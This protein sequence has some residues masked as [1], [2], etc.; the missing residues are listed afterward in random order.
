MTTTSDTY[1]FTVPM[2]PDLYE[3]LKAHCTAQQVPMTVYVRELLK[4]ALA[5][6]A[7]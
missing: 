4:Q 2:R 7:S 1:R 5:D 3:R 6:Q